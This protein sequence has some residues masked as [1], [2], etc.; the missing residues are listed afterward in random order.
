MSDVTTPMS[1]LMQGVIPYIALPGADDAVAFY[2]RAFGAI[3]H[4]D[5]H[6]D[7]RGRMYHAC[8]EI[9]G[10]ALMLSEHMP[11]TGETPMQGGSGCTLQ[12]VT[13]DGEAFFRR[14]VEAGCDVTMPFEEQFWGDR[15]GRLTDPFGLAWAVNEPS[16]ANRAAHG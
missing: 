8:L 5:I 7:D 11:E 15:Y 12:I 3:L 14:A 16:P 10:G 13:D 1:R 4:G 6:R 2:R 9:N